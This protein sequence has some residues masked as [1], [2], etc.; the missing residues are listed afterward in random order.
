MKNTL[1]CMLALSAV[2]AFAQPAKKGKE[3]K[4]APV[5][6]PGYYLSLKGDTVKGEVQTNLDKEEQLYTTI[7]FK[8]KGAAKATEVSTKKAKGYG[9]DNNHFILFKIGENDLYLKYLEKGRLDL[10]EYKFAKNVDGVEKMVPAYFIRDSK[11]PDDD[12]FQTNIITQIPTEHNH[13]K[14]LKN[15]FRDQPI[16]LDQVDKWVFNI[17]EIKKAVREFNAMYTT[18]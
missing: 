16:L 5:F 13:K 12:K 11:A 7:F 10:L 8:A 17:E 1:I 2:T 3:A 4:M 6:A 18:E 14:V 9:Y 15:F